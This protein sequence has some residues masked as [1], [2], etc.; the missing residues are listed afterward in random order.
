MSASA[1]VMATRASASVAPSARLNEIVVASSVSWWLTEVAVGPSM[2][3][4]ITF[5]GTMLSGVLLSTLPPDALRSAGLGETGTVATGVAA[6]APP[7][8]V[9]LLELA[10]VLS[11]ATSLPPLLTSLVPGT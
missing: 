8:A 7:A 1:S 3:R 2:K 6:A 4:A 11:T 9:L 10:A 5:S